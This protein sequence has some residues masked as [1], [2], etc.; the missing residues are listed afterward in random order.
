MT[1]GKKHIQT[2]SRNKEED[3]EAEGN[4]PPSGRTKRG[5]EGRKAYARYVERWADKRDATGCTRLRDVFMDGGMMK[6]T[7]KRGETEKRL[8]A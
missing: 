5:D 6:K 8:R 3:A 1:A 7:K 2:R 4:L